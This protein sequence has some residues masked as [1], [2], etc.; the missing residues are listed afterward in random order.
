VAKKWRIIIIALSTLAVAGPLWLLL[1]SSEPTYQGKTLTDWLSEY[2]DDLLQA[3]AT[4]LANSKLAIKAIGTNGI[5]TLL[6]L[7]QAKDIKGTQQLESFVQRLGLKSFQITHAKEKWELADRGFVLLG[8]D[9]GSAAPALANLLKTS[10]PEPALYVLSSLVNI[11]PPKEI[12]L[13]ALIDQLSNTN[14]DLG[15]YSAYYFKDLYP[16]EAEKAGVY[17]LFPKLRPPL[18]Q[19]SRSH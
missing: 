13:P 3:D 12:A 19:H 9:A 4:E 5:P 17:N 6:K 7:L 8:K 10:P 18:Q 14:K 1:R 15:W 2:H 16:D 11:K